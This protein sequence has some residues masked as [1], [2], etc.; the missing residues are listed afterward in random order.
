MF[1]WG[2]FFV[3]N[4][5]GISDIVGGCQYFQIMLNQFVNLFGIHGVSK[6]CA[7]CKLSI[8]LD[9]AASICRYFLEYMERYAVDIFG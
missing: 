2:M 8:F 9:N 5:W 6:K 3:W 1:F 7:I 4:T